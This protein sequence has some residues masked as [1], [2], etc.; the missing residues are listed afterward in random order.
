MA[1]INKMNFDGAYQH[2]YGL[3]EGY[4][5]PS[6]LDALPWDKNILWPSDHMGLKK[7]HNTHLFLYKISHS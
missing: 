1:T 5:F 6:T 2:S 4:W 3:S 7:T